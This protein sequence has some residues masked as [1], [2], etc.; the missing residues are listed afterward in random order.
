MLSYWLRAALR[1]FVV[2]EGGYG[3]Q[4]EVVAEGQAVGTEIKNDPG[5]EAVADLVAQGRAG[6]GLD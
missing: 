1:R 3:E 5:G 6:P 2:P 4:R